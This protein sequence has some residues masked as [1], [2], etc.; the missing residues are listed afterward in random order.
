MAS[1][2]ALLLA[3]IDRDIDTQ[4]W[5]RD[6][7]IDRLDMGAA[8]HAHIRINQLLEQRLTLTGGARGRAA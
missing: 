4:V 8:W 1:A 5:L 2:P 3:S 7:A 6:K